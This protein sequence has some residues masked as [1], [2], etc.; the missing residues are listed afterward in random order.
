LIFEIFALFG[1]LSSGVMMMVSSKMTG[2]MTN[3]ALAAMNDS[4]VYAL[5]MKIMLPV[6]LIV[7]S[8]GI[9][10]A[11]AL[12]KGRE[13]ARKGGIWLSLF[14]ILSTAA[15]TWMTLAYVT[16]AMEKYM[17]ATMAKAGQSQETAMIQSTMKIASMV[18][19]IGGTLFWVAVSV[20]MIILLTRPSAKVW[21][22]RDQLPPATPPPIQA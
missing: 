8:L 13:W 2:P 14:K 20:T 12:F 15:G 6:S 10:V 22:L 18:G 21:C 19:A 1:V 4:P 17:A 9:A 7:G 3:P 11:I 16:P 5:Y